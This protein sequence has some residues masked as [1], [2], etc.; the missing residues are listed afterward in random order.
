[1]A[2][3]VPSWPEEGPPDPGTA[4]LVGDVTPD[5]AVA[6]PRRLGLRIGTR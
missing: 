3:P 1:M 5:V 6:A 4:P 2:G